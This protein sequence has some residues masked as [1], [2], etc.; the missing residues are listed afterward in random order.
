MPTSLKCFL[1]FNCFFFHFGLLLTSHDT[2]VLVYAYHYLNFK[3]SL[4]NGIYEDL[5]EKSNLRNTSKK[6]G[7][8]REWRYYWKKLIVKS[9]QIWRNIWVIKNCGKQKESWKKWEKTVSTGT[10]DS[11]HCNG[12]IK[13]V[14]GPW[15]TTVGTVAA[16]SKRQVSSVMIVLSF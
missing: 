11:Q 13:D 9:F 10:E 1:F 8:G 12:F 14:A 15:A 3:D 7:E 4:E 6:W 2:P 5:V 16:G